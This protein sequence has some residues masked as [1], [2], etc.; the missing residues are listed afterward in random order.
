MI[1]AILFTVMKFRNIKV[2]L[3]R[4]N[5]AGSVSNDPNLTIRRQNLQN[6][7][8]VMTCQNSNYYVRGQKESKY[9]LY[10]TATEISFTR[11]TAHIFHKRNNV[12]CFTYLFH[13]PL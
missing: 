8:G 12:A 6:I 3:A 13:T 1:P 11:Q 10:D 9:S 7:T 5:D 2:L 4:F